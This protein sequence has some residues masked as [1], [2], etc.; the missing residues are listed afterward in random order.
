[1][2]EVCRHVSFSPHSVS[3]SPAHPPLGAGMCINMPLW[4]FSSAG[5][6]CVVADEPCH[7]LCSLLKRASDLLRRV[8][9]KSERADITL[10]KHSPRKPLKWL[11]YRKWQPARPDRSHRAN[12]VYEWSMLLCFIRA[13][14]HASELH[15][16]HSRLG[17]AYLGLCKTLSPECFFA[18]G[19]THLCLWWR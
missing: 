18:S 2:S 19:Q 11:G 6:R 3:G 8:P 13:L 12:T 16:K 1:M 15:K 14:V 7:W 9:A 5:M 10:L 4:A 17:H